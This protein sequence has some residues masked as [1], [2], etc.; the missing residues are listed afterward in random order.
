MRIYLLRHGE[1]VD[2]VEDAYGGIADYPLTEAGRQTATM[3]AKKL[4]SKGIK[5]IYTSPYRRALET[6]Q[7]L[8]GEWKAE[9]SIKDGLRERNS[10]GVLSGVTKTKAK[11]IFGHVLAELKGKPGDYYSTELV[12]GAEPLSEVVVRIKFT[13][14]E[15]MTACVAKYDEIAIVTHGNVTRTIYEHILHVKRKVGLDLLAITVLHWAPP[16][17]QIEH[18]EG[19]D[20]HD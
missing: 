8:A 20:I 16:N 17:L 15:I 1:S 12:P 6:A 13:L 14:D 9:L 7:I 3:L 2:D 18:T 10:Y 11:D 4:A 19:V 5:V